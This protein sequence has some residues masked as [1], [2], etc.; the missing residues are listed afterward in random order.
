MNWF[1]TYQSTRDIDE[2]I[3]EFAFGKDESTKDDWQRALNVEINGKHVK[4]LTYAKGVRDAHDNV[5]TRFVNW[6]KGVMDAA[7]GLPQYDPKETKDGE[8]DG[9]YYWCTAKDLETNMYSVYT[10]AAEAGYQSIVDW[11]EAADKKREVWMPISKQTIIYYEHKSDSRDDDD[12]LQISSLGRFRRGTQLP[13]WGE[14]NNDFGH[15]CI[16]LSSVDYLVC[17]TFFNIPPRNAQT[18]ARRSMVITHT[19]GN[20]KDSSLD[21][22]R[23]SFVILSEND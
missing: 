8:T 9:K 23:V 11:V 16:G 10:H 20:N 19:N 5:L 3:F 18:H 22:L 1:E 17:Q 4:S 2:L 12:N 7:E 21:N 13:T 15:N 14:T 6:V